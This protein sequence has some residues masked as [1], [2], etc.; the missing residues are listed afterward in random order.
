MKPINLSSPEFDELH[1]NHS[2]HHTA[3]RCEHTTRHGDVSTPHCMAMNACANVNKS[4]QVPTFLLIFQWMPIQDWMY[5]TEYSSGCLSIYYINNRAKYENKSVYL[6]KGGERTTVGAVVKYVSYTERCRCSIL[7]IIH[8]RTLLP[9]KWTQSFLCTASWCTG[10]YYQPQHKLLFKLPVNL[11]N[12]TS[13]RISMGD[14]M[15]TGESSTKVLPPTRTPSVFPM[16]SMRSA[17]SRLQNP[18]S[19]MLHSFYWP[20]AYPSVS[21]IY[22]SVSHIYEQEL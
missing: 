16:Q 22:P 21:H 1:F 2:P 12:L 14:C 20:W 7:D 11:N 19:F 5:A 3:W 9:I 8:I 6:A 13:L 15:L 10:F 4:Q 18:H 17:T